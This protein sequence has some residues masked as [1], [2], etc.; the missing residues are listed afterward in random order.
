MDTK[1]YFNKYFD[2]DIILYHFFLPMNYFGLNWCLFFYLIEKVKIFN[3]F[4]PTITV[5]Y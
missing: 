1:D 5:L 3:F 2:M 4:Y